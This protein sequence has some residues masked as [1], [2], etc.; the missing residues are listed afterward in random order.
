MPSKSA[1]STRTD[2]SSSSC[3]VSSPSRTMIFSTP[4][5]LARGAR[6]PEDLGVWL[7][8]SDDEREVLVEVH[9]E[10]LGALAHRLAVDRRREGR[11]LHLLL[12]RLGR[13]PFD[14]LG[15]HVGA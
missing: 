3:P 2:C 1:S 11:R 8:R 5:R 9:T 10:E 4:A 15:T 6:Q 14:A 13:E 12:D 7:Q